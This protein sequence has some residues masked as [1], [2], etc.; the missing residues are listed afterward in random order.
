[1]LGRHV[2][3]KPDCGKPITWSRLAP[4][5]CHRKC[6]VL[7]RLQRTIVHE[8]PKVHCGVLELEC[9][10]V[11]ELAEVWS[12][13]QQGGIAATSADLM[14]IDRIQCCNALNETPVL[15]LILVLQHHK[16]VHIIS[17]GNE[18]P[19]H[20]P[21]AAAARFAEALRN[22]DSP[23][24]ALQRSHKTL[25]HRGACSRIVFCQSLGRR[26]RPQT[27]YGSSSQPTRCASGL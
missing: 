12:Q 26:C 23:C 24:L 1:M 3:G 15:S 6:T 7:T 11:G 9:P 22:P 13:P 17:T 14:C 2:N 4:L 20:S 16:Y 8:L 25:L 10:G 27:P 5:Q 18:A 19:L 21:C